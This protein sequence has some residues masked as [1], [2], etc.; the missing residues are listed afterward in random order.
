[1]EIFRWLLRN[2][3]NKIDIDWIET[4]ILDVPGGSAG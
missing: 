4:K 3:I 1:M 2:G